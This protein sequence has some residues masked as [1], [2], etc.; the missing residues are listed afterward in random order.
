MVEFYDVAGGEFLESFGRGTKRDSG[1]M[2]R[3][4]DE[5]HS[6]GTIATKI[7][8]MSDFEV[9]IASLFDLHKSH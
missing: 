3:M 9:S 1:R 5:F 7:F 4:V 6:N 8:P 2:Y